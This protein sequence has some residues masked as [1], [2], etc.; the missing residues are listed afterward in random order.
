MLK[1]LTIN[2]SSD[3]KL[4]NKIKTKR[5]NKEQG[6]KQ[7]V[8]KSNWLSLPYPFTLKFKLSKIK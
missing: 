4:N 7:E 1:V 8:S 3:F 2:G 5:T 6:L